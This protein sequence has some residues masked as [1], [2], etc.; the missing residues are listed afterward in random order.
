MRKGDIVEAE[1]LG[2]CE[3]NNCFS[4]AVLRPSMIVPNHTLDYN[5]TTAIPSFIQIGAV[6]AT[7]GFLNVRAHVGEPTY[8]L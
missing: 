3:G 5:A 1:V 8:T 2:E 4:Y 6:T 7:P